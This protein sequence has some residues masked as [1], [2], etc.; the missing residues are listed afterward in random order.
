MNETETKRERVRDIM[1][2]E[3]RHR[4]L[5]RARER[6]RAWSVY[7]TRDIYIVGDV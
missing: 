2:T 4:G 7:K 5:N 6:D 3:Y 1:I